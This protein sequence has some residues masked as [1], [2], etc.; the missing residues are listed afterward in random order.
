MGLWR[1]QWPIQLCKVSGPTG[2]I[3]LILLSGTLVCGRMLNSFAG[4]F[5]IVQVALGKI[6]GVIWRTLS[7]LTV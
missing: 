2:L 4:N 1:I 3:S 6:I 5:L 7:F